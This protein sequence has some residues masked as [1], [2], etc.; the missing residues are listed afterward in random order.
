MTLL[1][2]LGIRPN[3]LT[4]SCGG[5]VK[6]VVDIAKRAA[7]VMAFAAAGMLVAAPARGQVLGDANSNGRFDATEWRTIEGCMVSAASASSS[8][9]GPPQQ[10]EADVN[11]DGKVTIDDLIAAHDGY[12]FA[13]DSGCTGWGDTTIGAPDIGQAF[14]GYVLP[15]SAHVFGA[16]AFVPTIP[17]PSLCLQV[18]GGNR[19]P[20][21]S[22]WFVGLFKMGEDRLLGRYER[23]WTEVG[24]AWIVGD[25]NGN[26]PPGDPQ[27][28]W[29]C[30]FWEFYDASISGA[31]ITEVRTAEL[32]P[33]EQYLDA[34]LQN[35]APPLFVVTW[36]LDGLP[37]HT[38]S[39]Q[40]WG[41]FTYGFTNRAHYLSEASD[42]QTRMPG[43]SI[44]H[45]RFSEC[46]WSPGSYGNWLGAD[47]TG[48]FSWHTAPAVHALSPPFGPQVPNSFD[49]WDR[50]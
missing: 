25:F 8:N 40:A 11:G 13:P 16:S 32:T 34:H 48:G 5:F 21:R 1:L 15:Y 47:L 43:T 14:A 2:T 28:P 9:C 50:R 27:A 3:H 41:Q 12:E 44:Q 6:N 45:C 7:A 18:I 36:N 42:V 23:L 37:Q 17:E 4:Q 22:L 20:T 10:S 39:H 29:K 30:V 35:G 19:Q 31:V 49:V 38:A 26:L 46:L 24:L 33:P